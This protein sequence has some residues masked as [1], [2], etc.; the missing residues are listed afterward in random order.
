MQGRKTLLLTLLALFGIWQGSRATIHRVPQH[1]DTIQ[2]AVNTAVDNDTILVAPGTYHESVY[3]TPQDLFITSE[4]LLHQ[5]SLLIYRTT[6]EGEDDSPTLYLSLGAQDAVTISGFTLSRDPDEQGHAITIYSGI[7]N[8]DHCVVENHAVTHYGAVYLSDAAIANVDNCIF[9]NNQTENDGAVFYAAYSSLDIAQCQ[10][11]DNYAGSDGGV[12][13]LYG[14]RFNCA[15][16]IFLANEAEEEGGVMV[17]DFLQTDNQIVRCRFDGN[18]SRGSASAIECYGYDDLLIRECYFGNNEIPDNIVSP[19]GGLIYVCDYDSTIKI[20]NNGFYNN[21]ASTYGSVSCLR[22]YGR[23]EG[24][25]YEGNETEKSIISLNC[26]NSINFVLQLRDNVFRD[27]V[28]QSEGENAGKGVLIA[29]STDVCLS[30]TDNDFHGNIGYAVGYPILATPQYNVENNYWGHASG[31]YHILQNEDGQGDTV[32]IELDILPFCTEPCN[33]MEP[34]EPFELLWPEN[35]SMNDTL[36]VRFSW[37]AANDPNPDDEIDYML[38]ISLTPQFTSSDKY[39]FI[40]GEN[41]IVENLE[42]ECT[43]YWRVTAYDN[44]WMDW[45]SETRTLTVTD[46]GL[47]PCA[48]NLDSPPNDT[49]IRDSILFVWDATIDC[50]TDDSVTYFL[51]LSPN[52]SFDN[53]MVWPTGSD[54]AI[55]VY[56]NELSPSGSR[57]S[58]RVKAVDTRGHCTLSNQVWNFNMLDVVGKQS[59]TL[60]LQFK[61]YPPHPNPFN[62]QVRITLAVPRAEHVR[63]EI[64]DILGRRHCVLYD[65]RLDAGWHEFQWYAKVASGTY[66]IR[67]QAGT[68]WISLT[69]VVLLR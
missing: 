40:T 4:Y 16:S 45:T 3:I 38:E 18:I 9:K 29:N 21:Y 66:F 31:P 10:F 44:V 50:S 7:L 5:D 6:W 13:Y 35:G 17:I 2:S 20:Y 22:A 48:F 23:I 15:Q 39:W 27:N 1:Y 52:G 14:G 55:V 28:V 60:P 26:V 47:A 25:Y 24:N 61:L 34:P 54:T 59:E 51:E 32:A 69:R 64:Y 30:A 8:L 33:I 46:I 19:Y 12:V 49:G 53:P 37:L 56:E 42:P 65:D 43:Y 68:E 62:Q 63:A 57:Y 58:W 67:V 36:P 41:H 11:I